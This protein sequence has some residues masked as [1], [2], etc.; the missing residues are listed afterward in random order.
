MN[1]TTLLPIADGGSAF[2]MFRGLHINPIPC[3]LNNVL[4]AAMLLLLLSVK[5]ERLQW[6]K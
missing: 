6:E 4:H 5:N 3:I 1:G 2:A